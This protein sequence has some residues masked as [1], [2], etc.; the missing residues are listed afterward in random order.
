M[1]RAKRPKRLP[2][3]L[4][5]QEIDAL[6]AQMEGTHGLMA[7]LL[8][9]TGMRLMECTRLRIKDVDLLRREILVREG[10]GFKDRVTRLPESLLVPLQAHL[11]RVRSLFDADRAQNFSG[12][13]LPDALD[14]KYPN[15]GKEWGGD[16][17]LRH[18]VG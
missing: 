8:Y 10:K 18:F 11:Q 7:R 5:R 12:V 4:N 6:L 2:V 1:L 16:I 15:G 17:S 3:V 14:K 9:G 13:Y